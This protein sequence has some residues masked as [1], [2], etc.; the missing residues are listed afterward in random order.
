M[1]TYT[2]NVKTAGTQVVGQT[3]IG[4][5]H[6]AIQAAVDNVNGLGGGSVFIEAGVYTV[7]TQISLYSNIEIYGEGEGSIL[8]SALT[9]SG[10]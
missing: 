6:V 2:V 7:S 1:F 3:Y 8:Q 5:T 10:N 4:T 9:F